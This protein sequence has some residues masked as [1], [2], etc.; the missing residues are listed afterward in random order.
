MTPA[1]IVV[2]VE[3]QAKKTTRH[4]VKMLEA[5]VNNPIAFK[6]GLQYTVLQ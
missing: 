4:Y 3:G 1:I 6:E 5:N 2:T